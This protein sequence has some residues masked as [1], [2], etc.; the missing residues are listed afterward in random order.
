MKERNSAPFQ[1]M[2]LKRF[3]HSHFAIHMTSISHWAIDMLKT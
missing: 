3:Q 2:R 1:N